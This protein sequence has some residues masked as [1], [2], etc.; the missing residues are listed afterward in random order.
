MCDNFKLKVLNLS[1][2]PDHLACATGVALA[3]CYPPSAAVRCCRSGQTSRAVLIPPISHDLPSPGRGRTSFACHERFHGGKCALAVARARSA[4]FVGGIQSAPM[5][6]QTTLDRV[7]GPHR[8]GCCRENTSYVRL[9]KV[10]RADR[11]QPKDVQA[12]MR[13]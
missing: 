8:C 5:T 10:G 4:V 13:A 9:I 6:M 3:F 2:S 7:V 1:A 12:R 11:H